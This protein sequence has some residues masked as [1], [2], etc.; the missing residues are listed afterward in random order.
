MPKGNGVGKRGNW[1]PLLRST[2]KKCN[3]ACE[4][5]E[6]I[7]QHSIRLSQAIAGLRLKAWPWNEA[8]TLQEGNVLYVIDAW[9]YIGSARNHDGLECILKT[10]L[11]RF[12]RDTYRILIKEYARLRPMMK[13]LSTWHAEP[14]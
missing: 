13:D 12:D 5:A 3:G 10:G 11:P 2:V 1:P 14:L 7:L 4:E 8:A 6:S 9:A